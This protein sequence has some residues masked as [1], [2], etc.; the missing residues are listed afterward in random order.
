MPLPCPKLRVLVAGTGAG[1][2]PMFLATQLGAEE[3]RVEVVSLDT[4]DLV[5]GLAEEKFG[6]SPTLVNS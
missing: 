1:V 3:G 2:L 4:N 5:V 6:L